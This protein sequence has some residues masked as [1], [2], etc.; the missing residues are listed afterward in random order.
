MGRGS[1][2]TSLGGT[3]LNSGTG[4]AGGRAAVEELKSHISTGNARPVLNEILAALEALIADGTTATIDL[5]AIP[6]AAG[7]ERLLDEVLGKGEVV[8]TLSVMGQSH[9]EETGIPGVWRIDH[10]D[11]NG[12]TLSRFVEIT[13][14]PEILKSQPEDAQSGLRRLAARLSELDGQTH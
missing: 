6:F 12:E 7:D 13:Y 5:G 11:E 10:F 4:H 1:L 14:L 8:A 9:V 2:G 3:A